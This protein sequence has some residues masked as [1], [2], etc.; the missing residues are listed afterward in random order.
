MELLTESFLHLSAISGSALLS[1][2]ALLLMVVIFLLIVSS[3]FVSGSEVAF[4][5]LQGLEISELRENSG[6]FALKALELLEKPRLL[7]ATILISNNLINISIIILFTILTEIV[8]G[9]QDNTILAFMIEVV[10]LTFVLVLFGEVIPKVYAAHNNIRFALA[11]SYPLF[12]LS[13]FFYPLAGFLVRYSSSFEKRVEKQKRN[14]VSSRELKEAIEITTGADTTKQENKILKGLVNFGNINVKQILRPRTD[15]VSIDQ[16][17]TFNELQKLIRKNPYSRIP[18]FKD[19]FD[20]VTGIL[21]VKDVLPH[22]NG[23]QEGIDWNKLIRPPYFVP[24][25]KKIDDLLKEFQS[26]KVHMAIV[27][28]EYGGTSGIVTMEDV[29]EEIVGEIGDEFDTDE[30]F[31]YMVDE[32]TFVFEGKSPLNDVIRIIEVDDEYFDDFKGDAET[33]GGLLLEINGQIPEIGELFSIKNLHIRVEG[34][35]KRRIRRVRVVKNQKN[36][37]QGKTREKNKNS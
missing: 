14:T 12:I 37:N 5:S 2:E 31:H 10:V 20:N 16:S 18:V 28:D 1:G 25:S 15:V 8:I 17:S 29:V 6:R 9:F 21:Y 4:F 27:V 33:I 7:L 23:Q 30:I 3:A 22:I 32:N 11:M 35:D 36:D 34:A 24:E 26:M 13:R 19:H